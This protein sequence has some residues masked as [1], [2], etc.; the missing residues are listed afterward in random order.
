MAH[1]SQESQYLNLSE[2]SVF[3]SPKQPCITV[4]VANVFF[5]SRNSRK[6]NSQRVY[7]GGVGV[8]LIGLEADDCLWQLPEFLPALNC[9]L[10][11]S[12]MVTRWLIWLHPSPPGSREKGMWEGGAFPFPPY[13]SS[14]TS[15]QASLARLWTLLATGNSPK[16]GLSLFYPLCWYEKKGQKIPNDAQHGDTEIDRDRAWSSLFHSECNNSVMFAT[17]SLDKQTEVTS[18]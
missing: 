2:P 7:L 10:G 3:F 9:S 17:S 18:P 5:Q 16:M 13:F 1:F 15:A 8:L 6:S 11:F 14:Q 4:S 12:F